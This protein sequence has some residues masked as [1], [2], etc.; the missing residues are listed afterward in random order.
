MTF[1]QFIATTGLTAGC[2]NGKKTSPKNIL[3]TAEKPISGK[4]GIEVLRGHMQSQTD[5]QKKTYLP[6]FYVISAHIMTLSDNLGMSK[7]PQ[8]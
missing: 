1:L 8:A 7:G 3:N 4:W 6:H 5:A 2:E